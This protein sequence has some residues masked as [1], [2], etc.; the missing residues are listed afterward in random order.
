MLNANFDT[1]YAAFRRRCF[2]RAAAL[3]LDLWDSDVDELYDLQIVDQTDAEL[4]ERLKEVVA[5]NS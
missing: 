1:K 4:D 3:K 5:N 2:A